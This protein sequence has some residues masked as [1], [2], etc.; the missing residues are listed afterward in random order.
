MSNF[1]VSKQQKDDYQK[2]GYTRLSNA[3]PSELLEKW[4][5]R[6]AQL[7]KQA[8]KAYY[9]GTPLTDACIIPDSIEPR[10]M[11]YNNIHIA[12]AELSLELLSC[13]ALTAIVR[14][15]CGRGAVPLQ[16]DLV[17]KQQHP[18]PVT[19]WHQDALH[20]RNHP[21][22]NIGIYLDN[23]LEGDGCLRCTP[24]T[25]HH[26]LD[27]EH[28]SA[29]H[30]W[31]VPGAIDIPAKAG[32]ILIHDMMLL[33]GSMPKRSP[34]VR[35]TI[36]VE[37]RPVEG[38]MDSG[39]HSMEWVELRKQWMAHV[40]AN[41]GKIEWPQAWQQDYPL[42]THDITHLMQQIYEQAEPNIPALWETNP[43]ELENYPVPKDMKNW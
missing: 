27:I 10:L 16:M 30:G 14:E 39:V 43:V 32:D 37:F 6:G 25:Q 33:H 38:I 13:P 18:Q 24:G 11:R 1:P 35:R 3:I 7:E 34:G 5:Q 17:Y 15:L 9:N 8:I 20:P 2:K 36:Y 31:E 26:S 19:K 23:A 29:N 21:Y 40:I 4:Q 12:D 28:I 42:T 22:L 41:G